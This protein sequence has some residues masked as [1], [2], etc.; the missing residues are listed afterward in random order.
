M[1][2]RAVRSGDASAAARARETIGDRFDDRF[3][4]ADALHVLAVEHGHRSW[5]AFTHDIEAGVGAG[6]RPVGRIGASPAAAYAESARRLLTGARR[7]EPAA[8]KRLRAHVP[9]LSRGDD[10]RIS[11][12]VT[13]ADTQ[14]CLAHE[15]GLRTWAELA[16]AAD[17][18][19]DEHFSRLPAASPWK[20]AEAA[21]RAGDAAKLRELLDTYPGLEQE[22]PGMTLLCAAA[23]PESR[24]Y[25]RLRAAARPRRRPG[26]RANVRTHA[27][28]LRGDEHP[29]RHHR[30]ARRS[31]RPARRTRRGPRRHTT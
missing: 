17:R 9:R 6:V 27:T 5:P 21:V 2:L 29:T 26:A 3:V 28:A 18:A 30:V 20:L 11:Q 19:H 15:Y 23:Q 22:D 7:G 12:D 16:E 4:L 10:N 8:L 1:L 13:A 25:P 14:V 24:A 31:R